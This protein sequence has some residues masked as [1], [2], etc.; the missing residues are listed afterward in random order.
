MYFINSKQLHEFTIFSCVFVHTYRL[1][2]KTCLIFIA[3]YIHI[4]DKTSWTYYRDNAALYCTDRR[5]NVWLRRR[6]SFSGSVDYVLWTFLVYPGI[7]SL[8]HLES[9][10]YTSECEWLAEEAKKFRRGLID[11]EYNSRQFF[12]TISF[13]H[14]T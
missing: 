3:F 14:F 8:G 9:L 5:V 6:F 11:I 10:R 2:D 12:T 13:Y 4:I 7:A 1:S